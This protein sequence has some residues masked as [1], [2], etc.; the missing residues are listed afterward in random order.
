MS[1]PEAARERGGCD[2]EQEEGWRGK[3]I[4]GK[5]RCVPGEPGDEPADKALEHIEHVLLRGRTLTPPSSPRELKAGQGAR[6][7]TCF[8]SPPWTQVV[9]PRLS[10]G[11][12]GHC[13]SAR[14]EPG[15]PKRG[16]GPSSPEGRG[17]YTN[18]ASPPS[19]LSFTLPHWLKQRRSGK[20]LPTGALVSPREVGRPVASACKVADGVGSP[21][22]WPNLPSNLALECA[23][24]AW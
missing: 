11:C 2:E 16:A 8:S 17:S 20:E 14:S 24:R 19:L 9:D 1:R 6:E 12:R 7:Q 13:L 15:G 3:H 23:V 5:G 10:D 18:E 4:T 22:D 21:K